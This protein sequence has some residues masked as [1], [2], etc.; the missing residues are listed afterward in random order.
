MEMKELKTL[1]PGD[2]LRVT[3]GSN[4]TQLAAFVRY[5][6]C[7]GQSS[8]VVKKYRAKSKTWTKPTHILPGEVIN[9]QGK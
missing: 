8:L 7:Q 9:R 3:F 4:G 1:R 2:T 5:G 6:I